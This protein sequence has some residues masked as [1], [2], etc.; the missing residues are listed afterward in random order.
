MGGFERIGARYFNAFQDVCI[1]LASRAIDEELVRRSA[2]RGQ[3]AFRW[4]IQ[5]EAAVAEALAKI[6]VPSDEDTPGIDEIDVLGAPAIV[7]LDNLVT[8]SPERQC[9][10][11]RGLLSFDVW[12]IEE[13]GCK[14]AAMTTNDQ[15]M[16]LRS[17]QQ[18]YE[19]WTA[20]VPSM[21]KVWR[22][23]RS[24]ARMRSGQFFAAQLYPQIRSDSLQV[25]YTSRVSWIWLEYDGPPMDEGYPRLEARR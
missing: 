5:E 15:I 1:S 18:V 14:F 10:Y 21:V 13:R 9:V 19:E 2:L 24:I 3:G 23:L 25:F 12:A 6:I 20:R 7:V 8:T 22:R 17:A 11:S 16:L 4:F